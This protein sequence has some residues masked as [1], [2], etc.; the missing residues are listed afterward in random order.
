MAVRPNLPYDT[1]FSIQRIFA[2]EAIEVI[3]A[4]NSRSINFALSAPARSPT[5]AR[6]TSTEP[7]LAVPQVQLLSGHSKLLSRTQRT[8]RSSPEVRP[9]TL[10]PL[11]RARAT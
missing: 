9:S 8:P 5:R 4:L 7:T 11:L 1:S 3:A 6:T 10:L 2:Q